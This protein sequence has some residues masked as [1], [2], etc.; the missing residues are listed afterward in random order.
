MIGRF[1]VESLSERIPEDSS[2]TRLAKE[3]LTIA[4]EALGFEGSSRVR[5][6][7]VKV[8]SEVEQ[9]LFHDEHGL[10]GGGSGGRVLTTAWSGADWA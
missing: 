4:V 7:R 5:G 6:S 3:I 1:S 9:Q 2:G 10:G 8:C